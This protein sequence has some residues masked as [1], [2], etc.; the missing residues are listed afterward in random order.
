MRVFFYKN[1]HGYNSKTETNL[2]VL[3]VL[4]VFLIVYL[5]AVDIFTSPPLNVHWTFRGGEGVRESRDLDVN[6]G[7]FEQIPNY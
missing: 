4:L 6:A 3:S 7:H 1:P 5:G 2:V